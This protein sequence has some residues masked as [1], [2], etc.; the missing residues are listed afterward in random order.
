MKYLQE[1]TILFPMAD[2]LTFI[3]IKQILVVMKKILI[4]LITLVASISV[5][6]YFLRRTPEKIMLQ[7]FEFDVTNFEH[8]IIYDKEEWNPNGD[9]YHTILIKF[10]KVTLA[11]LEYLKNSNL[12]Q[13]PN[14]TV[15][16]PN[17]IPLKWEK[18]QRGYYKL[19]FFDS[20]IRNFKILLIDLKNKELLMYYQLE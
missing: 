16:P 15:L 6:Y 17:S 14:K 8:K 2:L 4:F 11:N 3:T 18:K 13:L 1:H 20:D 10:D 12:L 7:L 5:S 19:I 9:G